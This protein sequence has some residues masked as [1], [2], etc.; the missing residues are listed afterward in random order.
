MRIMRRTARSGLVEAGDGRYRYG[1]VPLMGWKRNLAVT[2]LAEF[3][4]VAAFVQVEAF[5]PLYVQELGV[6]GRLEER[7]WS[8]VVVAAPALTMAL[9]APLWGLLGD[10][11]G[12]KLMVVRALLGGALVV[13]LMGTVASAEQLALLRLMQGVLAGSVTAA[14]VLVASTV[15]HRRVGYSLGLLWVAVHAG[16]SVG[17]VVGGAVVD[18]WGFPAACYLGSVLLLAAGGLVV[19]FVTDRPPGTRG[20]GEEAPGRGRTGTAGVRGNRLSLRQLL[21][22]PALAGVLG[23]RLFAGLAVQVLSPVLPFFVEEIAPPG[24][25]VAWLTGLVSGAGA[26]AGAVGAF[27]L[28]RVGDR[29]GHWIVLLSCSVAAGLGHLPQGFAA[30]AGTLLALRALT[31]LAS[32]G[33]LTSIIASLATLSPPGQE[34]IVYGLE[35]TATSIANGLGPLLGS[36]AAAWLGL[37]LPFFIAAGLYCL[38][39]VIVG[40]RARVGQ[41]A[42]GK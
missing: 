8:G 33:M 7:V 30:N 11:Y 37:R 1:A 19:G 15:P 36:V 6:G 2:W 26:A 20:Q 12:R 18:S 10:H 28:G 16:A 42:A 25:P 14:N 5:L 27:W 29:R 34:G 4:A 21:G 13:G 22:V 23:A 40:G 24:A 31:G 39:A 3:V 38:A 17:P 35:G 9:S 41:R 32:G